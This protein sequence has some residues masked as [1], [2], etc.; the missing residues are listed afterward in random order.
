MT[1]K[2][3]IFIEWLAGELLLRLRRLESDLIASG[4]TVRLE[5]HVTEAA[6]LRMTLSVELGADDPA[7]LS[8]DVWTAAKGWRVECDAAYDSGQIIATGPF[9]VV[10]S[11]QDNDNILNLRDWLDKFDV[12]VGSI[13]CITVTVH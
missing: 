7:V 1:G 6:P 13:I 4:L 2:R 12:F 5:R 10:E 11:E 3:V 9:T 8:I